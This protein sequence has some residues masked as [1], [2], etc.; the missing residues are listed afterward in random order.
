MK[1]TLGNVNKY[2]DSVKPEEKK[3]AFQEISVDIIDAFDKPDD[4]KNRL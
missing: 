2:L 4:L 1:R 3:K